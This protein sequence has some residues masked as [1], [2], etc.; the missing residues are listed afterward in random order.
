VGLAWL[1]RK[2]GWW[3]WVA[4]LMVAIV[5]VGTV[6]SGID[7]VSLNTG[8]IL[9]SADWTFHTGDFPSNWSRF[10]RS[11]T[12]KRISND[13]P[14][15]YPR[16]GSW[17][18]LETGIR[19][20]PSRW[21]LWF[22]GPLIISGIKDDF[23]VSIEPTAIT[24][25]VIALGP[26]T[27]QI[28]I[29]D[30]IMRASGIYSAWRDGRLL[31][32]SSSQIVAQLRDG[33][34][35]WS[36]MS[37]DGIAFHSKGD[38]SFSVDVSADEEIDVNISLGAVQ[39]RTPSRAEY[40]SI[41]WPETPIVSV[42][43][44]GVDMDAIVVPE[45]DWPEFPGSAD[46]AKTWKDFET[47]L[48]EGW[49]AGADTTQFALF[50]VDTSE[51]IPVPDAAVYS[52]SE[53]LLVPLLPPPNAIAYEWSGTAGWMTPWLGEGANLFVVADDRSRVFTNQEATMAKL[54]ARRR[55]GRIASDDA[56]IEIDAPRLARVLTDI[57]R[58]AAKDE[59]VPERNADDVEQ[60]IIPW[61]KAFGALGEIRFE[62]K[63]ENGGLT[64]RGGTHAP[65]AESAS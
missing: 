41:D 6:G 16:I 39:H 31:V 12:F 58:R 1:E 60:E 5:S 4:L 50:D 18:R 20:T 7:V 33:G 63:Y 9:P 57:T 51:G 64:L 48:P 59:L 30:G 65:P 55:A 28:K 35:F 37:Y 10:E 56:R 52:R 3:G 32:G 23:V 27:G 15:I 34:E 19:W 45:D 62:G 36:K 43:S 26:I 54:M 21:R 25:M 44:R 46:L 49:R 13:A 11:S 53:T 17:M 47:L 22:G 61:L 8:Y 14:E 29:E 24:R 42:V 2:R 40:F 38:H